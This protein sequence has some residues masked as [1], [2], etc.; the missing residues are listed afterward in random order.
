MS[1]ENDTNFAE[2]IQGLNETV[3]MKALFNSK[4]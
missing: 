3:L 4:S 1:E 2:L